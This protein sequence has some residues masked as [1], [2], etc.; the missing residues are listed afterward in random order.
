MFESNNIKYKI[1]GSLIE[2]SEQ[3]DKEVA[4]LIL[5]SV[6]DKCDALESC[7]PGLTKTEIAV[8]VALE[9]AKEKHELKR[10]H[11]NALDDIEVLIKDTLESLPV[12]NALDA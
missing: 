4:S 3:D 10:A 11:N 2:L 6:K 7:R 12:D 5:K 9:I 1:L 8:L